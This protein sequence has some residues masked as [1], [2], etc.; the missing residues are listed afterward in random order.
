M[1]LKQS[2]GT[3]SKMRACKNNVVKESAHNSFNVLTYLNIL[4][5]YP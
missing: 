3:V 2:L 5:Y 1:I 4:P